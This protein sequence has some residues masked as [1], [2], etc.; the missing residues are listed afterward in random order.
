ML[1]WC[2]SGMIV[3]ACRGT[4]AAKVTVAV[5]LRKREKMVLKRIMKEDREI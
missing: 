1:G 5:V 3:V 2:G 4:L